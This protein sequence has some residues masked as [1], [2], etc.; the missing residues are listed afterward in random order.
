MKRTQTF[1]VNARLAEVNKF[2]DHIHDVDSVHNLV[3]GRPV[4]H[5]SVVLL[6]KSLHQLAVFFDNVVRPRTGG[7]G[8]RKQHGAR[9]VLV[10]D[11]PAHPTDAQA[12]AHLYPLLFAFGV[13]LA[14]ATGFGGTALGDEDGDAF[15][16]SCLGALTQVFAMGGCIEMNGIHDVAETLEGTLGNEVDVL[17]PMRTADQYDVVGVVFAYLANHLGGIFLQICSGVFDGLVVNL[18]DDVWVLA[19]FLGHLAEELLG[20]LGL[21]NVRV[22]VDD[23]IDIVLD[24]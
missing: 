7:C 20:F 22:P 4:Y 3:Y 9:L 13:Y 12:L 10:A 23:D 14:V 19:V 15:L 8:T 2:A 17:I 21:Q 6:Q 1:V 24:G 5:L 18:V 11:A 16:D